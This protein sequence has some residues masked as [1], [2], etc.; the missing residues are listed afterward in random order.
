MGFVVSG[1]L[2]VFS[3][4]GFTTL[5]RETSIRVALWPLSMVARLHVLYVYNVKAWGYFRGK[6]DNARTESLMRA[7]NLV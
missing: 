6:S 2:F 3:L 7:I 5:I 4:K 1:D